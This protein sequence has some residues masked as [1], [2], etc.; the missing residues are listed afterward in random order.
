MKKRH[1]CATIELWINLGG[2][3]ST[4]AARVALDYA[5]SDSYASFVFN[6][7]P[8]EPI[9]WWLHAARY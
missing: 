4:Q 5:S 3:F 7:L 1:S 9:T 2:L 6:N 8:R